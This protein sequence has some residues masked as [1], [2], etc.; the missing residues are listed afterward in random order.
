MTGWRVGFAVGN[1]EA[2]AALAKVKTNVDSGVFQAIQEAAITALE[3]WKTLRDHNSKIYEHRRDLVLEVLKRLGIRCF[4]PRSTFYAYL[5][6]TLKSSKY[7]IRW[8]AQTPYEG[9]IKANIVAIGQVLP[10]VR[11]K[12]RGTIVTWANP[13]TITEVDSGLRFGVQRQIAS[14]KILTVPMIGMQEQA[15]L[16]DSTTAGLDRG[17][18]RLSSSASMPIA[19]TLGDSSGLLAGAW[20]RMMGSRDPGVYIPRIARGTPDTGTLLGQEQVGH[21]SRITS[22]PRYTDRYGIETGAVYGAVYIGENVVFEG[23]L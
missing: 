17:Y 22:E 7:M 13:S 4:Y 14:R 12:D 21:Y 16:L 2:V 3:N 18:Y 23:E 20:Q 15:A 5:L 6:P 10:L 1:R 9:Y 8:G 19:G 11:T